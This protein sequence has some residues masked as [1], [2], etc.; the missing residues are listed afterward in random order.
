[1][2]FRNQFSSIDY[3]VKHVTH[4]SSICVLS[5]LVGFLSLVFLGFGSIFLKVMVQ[6]RINV[7]GS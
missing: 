7:H 1:M 3:F 6:I 5:L 2:G 4:Y